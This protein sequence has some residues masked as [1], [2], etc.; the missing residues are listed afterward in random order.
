MILQ[1][2]DMTNTLQQAGAA[3]AYL[4]SEG[5]SAS[6]IIISIVPILL[7][8]PYIQRY[9]MKGIMVGAVKG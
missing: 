4:T 1:Q 8:Y 5:I 6:I 7:A 9:F 3:S 2:E